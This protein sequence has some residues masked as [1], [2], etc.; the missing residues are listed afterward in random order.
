[1]TTSTDDQLYASKADATFTG[2]SGNDSM[3]GSAGYDMMY[4]LAGDDTLNGG[5][6]WDTLEGGEGNDFLNGGKGGNV[7]SYASATSGVMVDLQAGTATGGAGNDHLTD[8]P[9]VTGSAYDD[10]LV[11]YD[12]SV[13]NIL[14]GEGGNDSVAGGAGND[15][16]Y[17]GSGDDTLVGGLDPDW[18]YGDA[19]SDTVVL[20]GPALDYVISYDSA[21]TQYWITDKVGGR[22]GTDFAYGVEFFKFSDTTVA[23][24][25]AISPG[26]TTSGNDTVN[27]TAA[28]EVIH[29]MSGNDS[30]KGGEGADTLFGGEGDDWME[31]GG[32]N[33][34]MDGGSGVDTLSFASATGAVNVNLNDKWAT[35][36]GS[37]TLAIGFEILVGGAFGDALSGVM[38]WDDTIYGGAGNDSIHGGKSSNGDDWLYG[39]AGDDTLAGFMGVDTMEGGSGNDVLLL[40]GNRADY[41]IEYHTSTGTYVVVDSQSSRDDTDYVKGVE[42]FQFADGTLAAEDLDAGTPTGGLNLTGT[43]GNDVLTGDVGDDTLDGGE[44]NDTLNGGAGDDIL[45]GGKGQNVVTGGSGNDALNDYGTGS[46]AVFTGNFADYSATYDAG[47]NTYTVTD[48]V[49]DRDGVDTVSV[50]I[51]TYQFADGT[52]SP[53]DL[54]PANTVNGTSGDDSLD[55]TAGQD[56]I[57]GFGGSDTLEGYT[58]NDALDG[59]DGTDFLYAGAGDDTLAGG[60]GAGNNLFGGEG[61]DTAVFDGDLA[62]YAVSYIY[63][64]G[65]YTV[66]AAEIGVDSFLMSIEYL[67]FADGVHEASEFLPNIVEGTGEDDVM[68]GTSG[69]DVLLGLAGNDSLMGL[70]DVDLLYGG[71]GNDTLVAGD[72]DDTLRG[73]A[74][75]DSLVG[76]TGTNA[77]WGGAGNDTISGGEGI[78]IAF[79]DEA[80]GAVAVNLQTGVVAGADGND[81]LFNVDVVAT[82]EYDDTIIGSDASEGLD[83]RGGSDS[84][85]GGAGDDSLY[86]G[87]GFDILDGGAGDDY[88]Y[89]GPDNDWVLYDT[90]SAA[91]NVDLAAGTA[92][93]GAGNDALSDLEAVM[94]SEFDDV[95]T[96]NGSANYLAGVLGNDTL[97]GNDGDDSL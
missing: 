22:D 80:T 37:D 34:Q 7:A 18:L 71:E 53:G 55:G 27:G 70:G 6:G 23:A 30:L 29:G 50:S 11:G 13:W 97:T 78:D 89:G 64:L 47:T 96:G 5:D 62:D 4:G 68:E 63:E 17:G 72:G 44:G 32:G 43:V 9:Y 61:T 73:E 90:A 69:E 48:S 10:T 1:M 52:H 14:R 8:I 58:G 31:G 94:G 66:A 25:S 45:Y 86:G 40:A 77:Y 74:G 83:G 82:G 49:A 33:D 60:G 2:T 88:L 59:G 92:T 57:Y 21:T 76:G 56:T 3:T 19:G 75:D 12:V 87:K 84:L 95:L 51:A 85:A 93:G 46:T 41:T 36:Q 65:L 20:A 24:A 81:L 42:F 16:L 39:E 67:Q 26:G 91:V 15:S 38:G 79:Y 54:L 35:G 28:A